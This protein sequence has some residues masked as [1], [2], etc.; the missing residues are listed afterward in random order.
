MKWPG[1]VNYRLRQEPGTERRNASPCNRR[2]RIG[3]DISPSGRS[4]TSSRVPLD[5]R[6]VPRRDSTNFSTLVLVDK[7]IRLLCRWGE[8]KDNSPSSLLVLHCLKKRKKL[9]R[10]FILSS[11]WVGSSRRVSGGCVLRGFIAESRH[12]ERH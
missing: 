2:A 4:P 6:Q 12:W 5:P 10:R 1:L 9:P 3:R 7:C 11:Y 8:K